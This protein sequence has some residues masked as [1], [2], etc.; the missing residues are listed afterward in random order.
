AEI[1]KSEAGILDSDPPGAIR[2]KAVARLE[3]RL[4]SDDPV[5]TTHVLLSSIGVP[6]EPDPIAGASPE[7]ARE[8]I[9]RCWRIFF[10]SVA[11]EGLV[12]HLL[13]DATAPAEAL[14]P[15]LRRS[16]GNPFFAQELLRMLVEDGYLVR[17]ETDWR[18]ERA[19]PS[20]L[21]DTVQG[22]IASRIDLL[23]AP[24]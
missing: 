24:E 11:G 8:L 5:S 3:R 15:V 21:P 16:E 4:R 7:V 2:D 22:V 14:A 17:G 9:A 10:E 23:P 18:L 19:L 20:T 1:L 6:V 13:G 12:R